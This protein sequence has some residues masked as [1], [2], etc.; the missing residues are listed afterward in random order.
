VNVVGSIEVSC[1]RD[2]ILEIWPGTRNAKAYEQGTRHLWKTPDPNAP[3][4]KLCARCGIP[5]ELIDAN[6]G[7][8]MPEAGQ[9]CKDRSA[10]AADVD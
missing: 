8:V 7:R 5:G 2:H 9:K 10:Q 6:N 1:E 3:E 4:S